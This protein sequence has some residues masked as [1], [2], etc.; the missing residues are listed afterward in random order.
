[1]SKENNG[2]GWELTAKILFFAGLGA[3]ILAPFIFWFGQGYKLW[4]PIKSDTVGQLGDFIG[5][6]VGSIWALAGVALF[7]SALKLQ[8]DEFS[9]QLSVNKETKDLIEKQTNTLTKQQVENTIFQLL[10][11]LH[12]SME[13]YRYNAQSSGFVEG[14]TAFKKMQEELSKLFKQ[15]HFI[16]DED[17]KRLLGNRYVEVKPDN[18]EES[19]MWFWEAL[20]EHFKLNDS[21]FRRV[22]LQFYNLIIFIG[23][24]PSLQPQ[25]KKDYI[26]LTK[27]SISHIAFRQ[28]LYYSRF[29]KPEPQR[30]IAILNTH[31]AINYDNMEGI[32]NLAF[33]REILASHL[34]NIT[35]DMNK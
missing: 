26:K 1:M 7:Y 12:R 29:R 21:R 27:A 33:H 34:K 6:V 31:E 24:N 32:Q 15:Q 11:L 19:E 30:A 35:I 16:S 23:E 18:K 4:T 13:N 28:F 2:K 10:G 9:N 25:E 14:D 20:D 8:R 3:F 17:S 5:G 22:A